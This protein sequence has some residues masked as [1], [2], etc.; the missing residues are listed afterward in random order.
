MRNQ[1]TFSLPR[2]R[3]D[4]LRMLAR[5]H[6]TNVSELIGTW[7]DQALKDAGLSADIPGVTISSAPDAVY[8]RGPGFDIGFPARQDAI[9]AADALER[10]ATRGGA[11]MT[12]LGNGSLEIAR[13]GS[14][15]ILIVSDHR[16]ESGNP[17]A[18]NVAR[19]LAKQL[20]A[21]VTDYEIGNVD[22]LLGDLESGADEAPA[23]QTEVIEMIGDLE[24]GT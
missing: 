16:G 22:T 2:E 8:F 17:F 6:G 11:W 14:G 13:Q 19:T 21:A 7:A 10:V 24:S 12:L 9:D 3:G 20:R 15:V 18:P 5:H 1:T 23:D 4:Q